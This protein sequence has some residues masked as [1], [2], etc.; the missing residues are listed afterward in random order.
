MQFLFS[1]FFLQIICLVHKLHSDSFW[2]LPTLWPWWCH[3]GCFIFSF[4]FF[5]TKSHKA[6]TEKEGFPCTSSGWSF[7]I[8]FNLLHPEWVKPTV[9]LYRINIKKDFY[10]NAKQEL[11]LL[12]C[13][14][15]FSLYDSHDMYFPL[16]HL[17]CN[18]LYT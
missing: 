18:F 7:L 9:L 3:S 15:V 1:V 5:W 12:F 11:I 14:Y 10:R 4:Y 6:Q 2:S 16:D 13:F 17:I 8:T